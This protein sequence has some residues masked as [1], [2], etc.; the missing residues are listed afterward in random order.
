MLIR[1]LSHQNY[2]EPLFPEGQSTG[3]GRSVQEPTQSSGQEFT[4]PAHLSTTPIGL[5][6]PFPCYSSPCFFLLSLH[7]LSLLYLQFRCLK[8]NCSTQPLQA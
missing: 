5:G 3:C 1:P 4:G 7:Q 8:K 6:F 2:E